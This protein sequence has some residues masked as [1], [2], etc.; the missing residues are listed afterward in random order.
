M[1]Q[2]SRCAEERAKLHYKRSAYIFNSRSNKC[3][4]RYAVRQA[5]GARPNLLRTHCRLRGI[6]INQLNKKI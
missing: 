4:A 2:S 1:L 6:V 3:Q 5:A